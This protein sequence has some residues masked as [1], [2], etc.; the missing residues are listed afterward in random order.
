MRL[1]VRSR[2]LASLIL[3]VLLMVSHCLVN[4]YVTCTL[5]RRATSALAHHSEVSDLASELLCQAQTVHNSALFY[6]SAGS[7]EAMARHESE[8]QQA[9]TQ[10]WA[11]VERFNQACRTPEEL[12]KVTDF[13]TSWNA[14][15]AI[16][17]ERLLPADKAEAE[18]LIADSGA[19]GIAAQEAF[20]RLDALA[21]A[22]RA[23]A[24][25]TV[26]RIGHQR[27][28]AQSV[29]LILM[30]GAVAIS[31]VL[32]LHTASRL[33]SAINSVRNAAQLVAEGDLEWSIAVNT[34]D[35]VEDIARLLT[36]VARRTR[37]SLATSRETTEQLQRQVSESRKLE[38]LLTREANR[39]GTL[40]GLLEQAVIV[41]NTN[42]RIVLLSQQAAEL[43]A[44]RRERAL[45]ES[46]GHVL[47]LLDETTGELRPSAADET[48]HARRM[49]RHSKRATLLDR[50]GAEHRIVL[51]S[52]PVLDGENQIAG[53]VIVFHEEV[54][55][56]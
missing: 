24:E 12:Q 25:D 31:V 6:I 16:L 30:L 28:R 44:W 50:E 49:V 19:A 51:D 35:E 5:D 22:I 11:L 47:Q 55:D 32:G 36:R 56:T 10:S 37:Q 26:M 17:I 18:V 20:N 38:G 3:I 21:Q 33:S 39:L 27:W 14:Y 13:H 46:I 54:Q 8:M 40:V 4:T 15:T 48:M 52:A 41:T 34:R 2:I 53:T 9:I 1:S 7:Q 43:T 42:G 23:A 45:G 29:L